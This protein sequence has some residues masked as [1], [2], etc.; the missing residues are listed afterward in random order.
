MTETDRLHN[1]PAMASVIEN[2]LIW[3]Q[4][5]GQPDDPGKDPH[6]ISK[7]TPESPMNLGDQRSIIVVTSC[8]PC[9]GPNAKVWDRA[10]FS[11]EEDNLVSIAAPGGTEGDP[12]P[13]IANQSSYAE[14]WGTSQAAGVVGGVSA[15][16]LSCYP[17]MARDGRFLKTRLLQTAQPFPRPGPRE[18]GL[19]VL[20]VRRAFLPPSQSWLDRGDGPQAI[21]EF[22]FCKEGERLKD[23]HG[24]FVSDSVDKDYRLGQILYLK[25]LS[26][27]RQ[28]SATYMNGRL[29][30][31]REVGPAAWAGNRPFMQIKTTATSAPEVV[32]GVE[33]KAFVPSMISLGGNVE[34]VSCSE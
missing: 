19:G 34:Y 9:F 6:Q 24:S 28:Y 27:K 2:K 12:I 11:D 10:N 8:D 29:A 7:L 26:G 5:V 15:A 20:D 22:K 16:L 21:A 25:T 18:K 30:K 4:A 32:R 3:I 1:P 14:G 17:E 31:R 23:T 13:A 33:I